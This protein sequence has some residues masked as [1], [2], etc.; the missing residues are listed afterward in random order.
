M[1][2]KLLTIPMDLWARIEGIANKYHIPTT[3]AIM[4]LIQEA[5]DHRDAK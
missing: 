4:M 2:K 5:L 1:K 3:S